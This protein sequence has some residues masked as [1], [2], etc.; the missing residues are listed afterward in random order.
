MP[1]GGRG[2]YILLTETT[3]LHSS[4]QSWQRVGNTEVDEQHVGPFPL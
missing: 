1:V 2:T 4:D 3:K